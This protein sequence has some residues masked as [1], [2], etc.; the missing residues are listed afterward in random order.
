MARIRTLDFLPEIFQTPTNSQ[1]LAATLD[2]IVNEPNTMRVQGYIGSRL[3]YGVNALDYYV[4]EPTKTRVDYQLDPSVVFTKPNETVAQDF[5]TYPG[6]VDAIKMQGGLTDDNSQLFQSQIYSWDSFTNLDKLVNYN[7]YY[8]LPDGPPAVTVAPTDVYSTGEYVVTSYDNT[9]GLTLQGEAPSGPTNPAIT[10]LRGGTY[11]FSVNQDSQFWIQTAPGISGYSPIQSNIPTREVYGVT[12][13]GAETGFVTFDVPVSS[14]QNEYIFPGDNKVDVVSTTPFDQINGQILDSFVDPESGQSY[15]GVNQIDGVN[16]TEGMRI[17]FYNTGVPAELGYISS[18][19]GETTYDVNDPTITDAKTINIASTNASGNYLTI[20]A[21]HTTAELVVNQTITFGTGLMGGLSAGTVYFVKTILNDTD[22]VIADRIGGNTIS[23]FNET[24]S[25]VANINQGQYQQGFYSVVRENFFRVT[26]VGDPSNPTIR[27]LPDGEIPVK[28]NITATYGTQWINRGFYRN[29]YNTINLIPIIT[30]NLDVLYYQD[31]TNPNKVGVIHLVD[32]SA[33]NFIDV[34]AQIL[35]KKNYTSPTGVAFTNGLKV[36]FQGNIVPASYL[37][38]EYYVENVGTAIELVPVAELVCPEKFTIAEYNPWDILAYDEGKFDVNL[39]IPVDQDYITIARNS[40]SKNAWSRSNRWFH[41]DVITATAEYNNNPAILT[42]YATLENKAK[43]PIIEFYPNLKLFNSGSFGKKAVDFFDTVST[44]ALSDVAGLRNYYPDTEAKTTK[45]AVIAGVTGTSTTITIPVGKITGA[46]Q[47]GMYVAD[48]NNILPINTQVQSIEVTDTNVILTVSWGSTKTVVGSTVVVVGTDSPVGNYAVFPGSRIVFAKDDDADVKDSIYVVN[49]TNS[50]NPVI[51]LSLAED[52]APLPDEM[53][54]VNRGYYYQGKSFYFD[55]TAWLPAQQK[56][57][58]NQAPLFDLFDSN[59][60]SLGNPDVYTSTSFKGC[61]LFAYGIGTGLDDAILGFPVSYSS[62]DNIGDIQFDVSINSQTFDYVSGSNSITENVNIGYA[63]S[64]TSPYTYDRLLGWKTAIAPSVQYQAFE[65]KYDP[66]VP[67]T[68]VVCDIAMTPELTFGETGWA[69]N[70]VFFNNEYQ[71]PTNYTVTVGES[72]TLITFNV[73][74]EIESVIQVLLLSDQVSKIAYYTIPTNLNNNP[75]N[76]NIAS[77]NLGDIRMQYMDI[78]VNAPGTTGTVFGINNFRDCGDLVAY[79]TKIIQNSASLVLPGA[80]LRK[81]D[82]SLIDAL[83]FNSREYVKYK[84]LLVD[85]VQNSEYVQRYTPSDI[86][87]DAIDQ[88]S[89]SRSEVNAFFW[90]DMLPSKAPYRSNTYSFNSMLDVTRFPLSTVYN[91]TSANYNSVL[92]YLTR[93]VD[94]VVFE[95]QLLRNVDYTV[96]QDAPT[97]TITLDLIPGDQVTIKE[98]NQ[99]YGSYVPNTPSKLG[100]YKLYQPEVVLDSNYSQ[101]TYFIKGH[102][103]SYTKIYGKYIPATETLIDFRDQALFE[104]EK[105]IY[106]NC[107]LSTEVPIQLYDIMPGFFRDSSYSW[108]QWIEMYSTSFLNWVGQNRID[109]KTQYYQRNNDWTYNYTNSGNKLNGSPILQG[110]WRGVYEYFY[111]T[112][113]PNATPW[114]MLGFANMPTWWTSRYGPAPYTSDNEVLW[115]DLEAGFVWN[116]GNSYTVAELARPGLSEIIPVDTNGDLSSPLNVLVGNYNPST[117]QKDWKVGDDGPAELSYRRSS[118]YPFDVIRLF[119]LTRPAELY[120]LGVD[121]DN[122]KYNT[123]FNQYLVNDRSHLVISD[124]EIYGNGVAKTS[125]IN[126]IVDFQKQLGLDATASITT[127]LDNLDVRLAY[128]LAGFSDKT[129]MNFYVEKGSPNNSNASLLI[130]DESYSVLLYENQP[131]DRLAYSSIVVQQNDGSWTVYGNSQNFAYFTTLKPTNN[132]AKEIV[133]VGNLNVKVATNYTNEEVLIPYG[134]KF[135]SVQELAQFIM[136][137]SAYLNAKGMKFNQVQNGVEMNWTLMVQEIL[138]WVQ[139]GWENGSIVTLNPSA[140][141]MF[142]DKAGSIVQP[143]TMYNQNFILNQ[144]LYPIQLNDLCVNRDGTSFHVHTMNQG[145]S[146]AYGQF[147]LSNIEHGIVFDNVTLFNDVIY[148]LVTGLRQ[149]RINLRGTKT[150]EWNGT[151]NAWGFILNQD[152]I[153]DWSK[154]IKYPKGIIVKYKNKYWTALSVVEPSA[155]FDEQEWKIVNYQDIQKGMLPN[156]ASRAYESTLYYN[157]DKANLEQDA[158]LLSFSLIGYRPR[159]YLALADLTDITQVN[160]YQNMIKNKG[161]RNAT[162]AFKGANLP[163][164]GIDY[165]VYENWAIKAGEYGGVLN[166]N[167]VEFKVNQNSMTGNPSIVSLTNGTA[168]P[169]SMQE[170]PLYSL[171]NYGRP[172]TD[173]NILSELPPSTPS[174]ILYPTAGY[175]NINDVRM[176]S[177]YYAGLPFAVDKSGANVPITDFYVRDYMWLA[178]F[179]EHWNVY[180]WSSIGEVV[181]VRANLNNTATVTFAAPHGL[182]QL[183]SLSIVNFATNVDGY[184]IVNE[185]V[186]INEVI[187]NLAIPNATSAIQGR[188]IAL[189]INSQRVGKPSEIANMNLLESEFTKNTVWVDENTDGDWAVYRKS[190]NYQLTTSLTHENALTFGSAVAY[191]PYFGYLVA[192]SS[193]GEVYRYDYDATLNQFNQNQVLS[194]STTYGTSIAH[195]GNIFAVSQPDTAVYVYVQNDSVVASDIVPYQTITAPGGV[196]DWGATLEFSGDSNWLYVSNVANTKVYVYRKQQFTVNAGYFTVGK[197]YQI[198]NVSTTDFTAI[199]AIENKA[200]ITFVAT[201]SGSGFGSATQVSYTLATII[202]GSATYTSANAFGKSISA[203]YDGSVV[204]IGVPNV[205]YNGTLSNWG[206][207]VVYQRTVQKFETIDAGYLGNPQ[208]F[209][210]TWTPASV[211]KTVASTNSSGN[212]VTLNNTTGLNVNDP[213]MFVGSNLIDTNVGEYVVYYVGSISGNDITLKTTRSTSTSLSV[214]TKAGITGVS[215]NVQTDLLY[216]Y[217]NGVMVPDSN[218]AVVGSQLLYATTL[219]VGDIVTVSDSQ[220]NVAQTLTSQNTERANIQFGYAQDVTNYGTEILVGSPY[221]IDSENREGQVYRFTNIGS[222]FGMVIATSSANVLSDTSILI[223]GFAVRLS[224]GNNTGAVANAINA[225]GIPNIQAASIDNRLVIQAIDSNLSEINQQLVITSVD[226]S[227]FAQLG[228]QVYKQTQI[229]TCPHAA[230]PTQFGKAIK[231]NE[232]DSVVIGA[233]VATRFEGTTFDFTDDENLHNDTVFDNNST[234]FVDEIPNAGTVYMFDLLSDYNGSE[235][236]PGAFVYAQSTNNIESI[237]GSS[238]MYGSVLDFD[239]NVVVVG[240]PNFL[241][242]IE[243]GQVTVYRNDTG[244]RDWAEYRQPCAVVDTSKI[245]TTQLFSAISNDTLINLDYMDPI[246]GK[247]LG[248]VRENIDYVAKLDPANYNSDFAPLTGMTWGVE[249]LGEIWFNTNSVRYMNYH[250]ND[251]VYNSK[252]WGTLFPG[253]DVAVYTWVES[254]VPPSSYVGPG[255]PF[256]PNLYTVGSVLNASNVVTPVYYFWVRNSGLISQKRDKTLADSTIAAYIADPK[257]SGI[258][259]MAPVLPNTFALYNAGDYFNANDT[260]FHIGY[261]NGTTDDVVHTEYTLIREN[262]NDDFLPGLPIITSTTDTEAYHG[263]YPT[264]SSL[265]P[266]LLYARM[267]D[268]LSGCNKTGEVVPDPFLPLAVQSGVLVRP[269]QSFFFDRLGA[270]KNYLQYANEVLIQYPITELKPD[271]SFLFTQGESYD[272]SNYWQYANWWAVGYS[273]SVRATFQVPVYADLVVLNVAIGTI[274]KVEKNGAG[275]YEI[276]RYDGTGVWTRVG[277]ENGTIQFSSALWDYEASKIGFGG[278]FF[279]TIPFDTYPSEETRQIVRALNEQIYTGDLISYRNKS[280]ILLFEYIQSETTESQNFLPW[281]NKTSLADVS[282]TIRELKPYEVFKSD[283][284]AFLEGYINEVKPYHVVVKEFLFNYTGME[285]YTGDLTDFDLPA[286]W[287]SSYN[288]FITPQLVYGNPTN[289][290]EYSSTSDIWNNASYSE[291]FTN[292]GLSLTGQNDVFMT[293]LAAYAPTGSTF[294]LVENASGFPING[295]VMI[296]SEIISYSYVDRALNILGG[297]VRG[298]HGTATADHLPGAEVR[299]D[300]PAVVVLDGGRGYIDPPK[301]E[302]Y[303]DTTKYPAPAV[304]AQLTAVMAG[305]RVLSI[306]VVNP[307]KGYVVLPEIIVAPSQEIFFEAASI[308]SMLHTINI[309]APYLKT[310]DQVRFVAGTNGITPTKLVSGSWYYVGV[311]ETTPSVIIALYTSYSDAVNDSARIEFVANNASD[312]MALLPGVRAT[313]ITSASPV[314][315]N[316]ITIKFDRTSYT[317]Q[318]TDWVEGAYYGAYFAGKFYNPNQVAS[319]AYTLE[320]TVP[321]I[322]TVLASSQGAPFEIVSVADDNSLDWS[323]YIRYVSATV[324]STG[325]I[326]LVPQD[327]NNPNLSELAPNASGTTIGMVKNMPIKFVGQVVGGLQ[328]NV[329][330]Y[331]SE[332]LSETSFRVSTSIDGASI[333][334]TDGAPITNL[335]R[336]FTGETVG[337]TVITVNYPGIMSVTETSNTSSA[338]NYLT[339]PMS[340]IGTGGTTGFYTQLPVFF[341][342]TVFGGVIENRTYYVTTVI[343]DERFTISETQVPEIT[344]VTATSTTGEITVGSTSGFIMN[345]PVIFTGTSFGG[346][347]AGQTYYVSEITGNT[348]MTLSETVNG[349]VV[350]YL[351][352]ASGSMQVTNQKDTVV[353]ANETGIMVINV[354]LPI[355]PGQVNGQLFNFYQTSGQYPNLNPTDYGNLL[356]SLVTAT[357]ATSNRV[358]LPYDQDTSN[359]YVNMP[360]QFDN[361]IGG[362]SAGTTYYVTSYSGEQ[363]TPT[364]TRLATTVKV[365]STSSVGNTL[366]CSATSPYDDTT[367]LYVGMPIKFAGV[368]LGGVTIDDMYYVAS[369]VDSTRFTISATLGGSTFVVTTTAPSAENYMVG[370]GD[371]YIT[372]SASVGGPNATLSTE[373]GVSTDR[374]QQVHGIPEFSISYILGG[375]QVTITDPG[376][377]FALDNTMLIPGTALGGVSPGNNLTLTVDEISSTGQILNVI[378]SGTLPSEMQQYYLEVRSP[379]TLA[380]YRNSGL[381]VPVPTSEFNFQ[382]F[383]TSTVTKVTSTDDSFYVDDTSVFSVNDQ[384]VFTG[385]VVS[386][387]TQ[388]ATYFVYEILSANRFSVSTVPGDVATKVNIATSVDPTNFTVAK[389]GSFAFLP[390]PFHFNESIVKFNNRLYVCVVSNNDTDFVLG[391]WQQINSDYPTLNAMD[392]AVGYYAPTANMPGLD[393][394]QLFDGTTFPYP[395]VKGNA[396]QPDQQYPID[397]IIQDTPFD[398]SITPQ[399]TIQGP[400][401]LYGYGPEELVPGNITDNIA[402]IVST[403]PGIDWPGVEYGHTG[404]N[405]VSVEITPT[406]YQTVFSFDN[407]VETPAQLTLQSLN[408]TSGLGTTIY[409]TQYTVNWVNKTITLAIPLTFGNKLRIDVYEVGNGDQIVKANTDTDPIRLNT[410]SLFTEIYVNCEYSQDFYQGSGVIR[411]GSSSLVTRVTATDETTNRIM[412]DDVTDFLVNKSI[413][414]QGVPF[415]G[416]L[417]DTVYYVKTISY[418]TNSITVSLTTSGGIAGPTVDLTTA[419]GTMFANIENGNG[420]PWT[421]PYVY[422]NGSRLVLGTTGIVTRTKAAPANTITTNTTGGL[423]VNDPITFCQCSFGGIVGLQRYYIKSIVDNNEFTIASPIS[424]GNLVVGQTYTIVDVGNTNWTLV[425]AATNTVGTTFTA[426]GTGTSSPTATGAVIGNALPLTAAIGNSRFITYD[427]AFGIQPD[428]VS[429]MIMFPV[430]TYTNAQDYIVYSLFGE[431]RPDQVGYSAPEVQ[432]ITSDGSSTYTLTNFVGGSN[433]ENAVV[434]LNGVR[435]S[436]DQYAISSLYNTITFSLTTSGSLMAMDMAAQTVSFTGAAP[437]AGANISVLTYNDTSRQYL[438]SQYNVSG[439]V[440]AISVVNNVI[441]SPIT[442]KIN[443]TTAGTNQI[444]V[445][446][447]GGTTGLVSGQTVMFKGNGG[448]TFGGLNTTGVVYFVDT[449]VDSTHFTV[450]DYNGTQVVLT[451]ATASIGNDLSFEVGNPPQ[452]TSLQQSAGSTTRITTATPH[453]LLDNNVV[454]I[455]GVYGSTQLNN[456]TFYVKYITPTVFDIYSQP[457]TYVQYADNTPVIGVSSYISGGYAWRSGSFFLSDATATSTTAVTNRIAVDSVD[458]FVTG[459]P[460][461]FSNTYSAFGDVLMGGLVQ[462]TEYYVNDVFDNNTFTVSSTRY[463]EDLVLTNG[464]GSVNVTQWSQENVNRLWVTINGYRVP[465]S[466]LRLNAANE[467][468]ILEAIATSDKIIITNMIPTAIPSEQIYM[469]L[470][471]AA[472]EPTVYNC[473]ASTRTWLTQQL[474]EVDDEIHVYDATR[475]TDTVTQTVTTPA[476]SSGFY[477]VGLDVDKR[478][479]SSVSITNVTKGAVIDSANYEVVLTDVA[480]QVKITAGS[481]ISQGDTLMIVSLEGNTIFINGEQIKFAH[482]DI[483]NN[484]LSGLERGANGTAIQTVIP[485]YIDVFGMLSSNMLSSVYYNQTWNS[486]VY[487]TV[488]GDPLQISQTVPA[489]FLNTDII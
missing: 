251:A 204:V 352:N 487:N 278:D 13:N 361:A 179:K 434:E 260:V 209:D 279:D 283:N 480:P 188:G 301:V 315:E 135:Y 148:N 264:A 423:N 88:I 267:L 331:V 324:S 132:S 377:G 189:A 295:N 290:Y 417:E 172:V 353:L 96:D 151:V 253:S 121:L 219:N 174:D 59:G 252:Y 158:D 134:T 330:Y 414:F 339:V 167:F 140:T 351:T 334:L 376:F 403:R 25:M 82:N 415:G 9:Y 453:G 49:F 26:F 381:T 409:P 116:N 455:D 372:V 153:Q 33:D 4:T 292:Q 362:L 218:Y 401:F 461:Y 111:D 60:V 341:T 306:D 57:T 481:W 2:Q 210:L 333:S 37:N 397:T 114:E 46:F 368:G 35:G 75:L 484:I 329:I 54:A 73:L 426:T 144:D 435:L 242:Y 136:S 175:V 194:E 206:N 270:L 71:D 108:D 20:A 355:S 16:I 271:L 470:V 387:I 364:T 458:G 159:D 261:A 207:S 239:Q 80:F 262:F 255:T 203:S 93:T 70:Q 100:L 446:S 384:V 421:D 406:Q 181:Q 454:R 431:T 156:A 128:R 72:T 38:N 328:E 232:F 6:L 319:S 298:V 81:Q 69:R 248:A 317:S 286:M 64:Y 313:T 464:T 349:V 28:E 31:G 130:P 428:G 359:Y 62:V 404:F 234:R 221:E 18:Y 382:G 55:G 32:A 40:I 83:L 467:L 39:N 66:A 131:F 293:R 379:Y 342:G 302:A 346:L 229:I 230:G 465:S 146:L 243:S 79:G 186:N 308:N 184:Y 338:Y 367:G 63:H 263:M 23:L 168:T 343:D 21:G 213:I 444:T 67:V 17:L 473:N 250:Q 370:T 280:L 14:A 310:G 394:T 371:P 226:S 48:Y 451:S 337:T 246:Q 29:D 325:A 475:V 202:D 237:N 92:V 236:N 161:T 216:V 98:Y 43:R 436:S 113:T 196:T 385:D 399:Y 276:Y 78:F 462:G 366:T 441:A 163:Q 19:Y 109:Y 241:P 141:D 388:N 231:F 450:K 327:G 326:T 27:L 123:E 110:Y 348:T 456:N 281:L 41:T 396:F 468:S 437:I 291:W 149:N 360:I 429:A 240:A 345:N 485:E 256:D 320:N 309:Y 265:E 258:A 211:V 284:E 101:P 463:G 357:I 225:S 400:E 432:Y 420:V 24:G 147:N 472:G 11:T 105:R 115:A 160:V 294:L 182:K 162:Y 52:A 142:I 214:T 233:P 452:L 7:E 124:V 277:L 392:R 176:S 488:K 287:N 122:Y 395:T 318:V 228:I 483:A 405:V 5:I 22:F 85:T 183:D 36:I 332:I 53:L 120:N 479:L 449:V 170:V 373:L 486:Y 369:I 154:N 12:N 169:G 350:S 439:T 155:V 200:G 95:T 61:K 274:A 152:N 42:T 365:V 94:G 187:I 133:A 375:Y 407:I 249:H 86:L 238:P 77:A 10:L 311:L 205:Y 177:F 445:S 3:G 68:S 321:D 245:Q 220:F 296:D 307:G 224:A 363:L 413:T 87:D 391:K 416:L 223:N 300:L 191:S 137:Y 418:A 259:Y 171:Y 247:L 316:N 411:T 157:R 117:F 322:N 150:A 91:F 58:T 386:E 476:V 312:T 34:E 440:S 272:T 103:G 65:F 425:G 469:N 347:V 164:G 314:R 126:W 412:C 282:H 106:N 285:V 340:P 212:I 90:S 383:T 235:A 482:I 402:M 51:V 474:N 356:S 422:H 173:P 374:F 44:D 358:T 443:A 45:T 227:V 459:T 430:A 303:I 102:D 193:V 393:L 185:I 424:I 112:T 195:A 460:V 269:R 335:L 297:I 275:L 190:L 119:A 390:E 1:F 15:Y 74:P 447:S 8:W 419:T 244:V 104:F 273:D 410:A 323:S 389:A 97:V 198:T 199:G 84:Q 268:S 30:A 304:P 99:T 478:L 50:T 344:T 166:E 336:C 217:V 145:D 433:P 215:A 118:S 192:D 489:T 477:Y 378:C 138:Y 257:N 380:V 466:K 76:Q 139:T 427:Y 56:V 408:A 354:S 129:L 125:Y 398:S 89:A 288:Q 471:N 305:D 201:G 107:K 457:Y 165:E 442:G 299:M 254:N 143:L 178:N 127:M 448:A 438:N 180:A 222:K 266:T 289:Q 197:T 208:F 47:V